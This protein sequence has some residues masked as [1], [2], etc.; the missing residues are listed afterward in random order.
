MAAARNRGVSEAR[1]S[2]VAPIDADDLW[3]PTKIA[4]Q[5][6]IMHE[7]GEK[8]GLVYTWL[9][10]IDP[11]DQVISLKHRPQEEGQVFLAMC[12]GNVV[13]NGSSPL[14]RRQIVLECG[15]YDPTLRA[16][17]AQ[18]CEDLQLYLKIAERYEF[19]LVKEHLT[20]YR[21]LPGNMSSDVRRH[22]P[23]ERAGFRGFRG[24]LSAARPNLPLRQELRL[25]VADGP[26]TERRPVPDSRR[27][28]HRGVTE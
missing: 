19:G 24:C 15:G 28:L 17:G 7:R 13:A 12:M 1:G 21:R 3:H 6:A 4:K 27:T 9:A 10:K 16:R 25:Q 20:G 26:C 23:I 18:G 11:H 14:M 22:V 5:M 8:V 2:F